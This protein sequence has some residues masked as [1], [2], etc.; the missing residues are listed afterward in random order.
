MAS[1]VAKESLSRSVVTI[2]SHTSSIKNASYPIMVLLIVRIE[3]IE[4]KAK[5]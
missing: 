4:G 3:G 1:P 5:P 2:V